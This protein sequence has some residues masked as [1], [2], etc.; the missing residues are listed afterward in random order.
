MQIFNIHLGREETLSN[1]QANLDGRFF[2]LH[3]V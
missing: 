3:D 1:Q 2:M